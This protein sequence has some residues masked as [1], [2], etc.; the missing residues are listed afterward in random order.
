[1]SSIV[2][3]IAWWIV[4][5]ILL[6]LWLEYRGKTS[7]DPATQQKYNSL[8]QGFMIAF[9]VWVSLPIAILIIQLLASMVV[10]RSMSNEVEKF[11]N[12]G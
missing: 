11:S 1:M 7:I 9:I 6:V 4:A 2:Y 8:S 10:I 3:I 5:T 12:E